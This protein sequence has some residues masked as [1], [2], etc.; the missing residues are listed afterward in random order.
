MSSADEV[1]ADERALG[2]E[3]QILLDVGTS[4]N[5]AVRAPTFWRSRAR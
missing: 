3:R 5:R 2:A 1:T 4:G